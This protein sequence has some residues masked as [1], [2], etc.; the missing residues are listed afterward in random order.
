MVTGVELASCNFSFDDASQVIEN[1][2][3]VA[4]DIQ[5]ELE[6]AQP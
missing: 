1:I 5:T 2:T 4:R 3:F 6:I